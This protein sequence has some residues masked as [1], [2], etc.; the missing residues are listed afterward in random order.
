MFNPQ[1]STLSAFQ[2]SRIGAFADLDETR[3]CAAYR[4]I[5]GPG[6]RLDTHCDGRRL[7]FWMPEQSWCA[8]LA[9]QLDIPAFAAVGPAWTAVRANWTLIPLNELLQR[10]ALSP[11]DAATIE[12]ADAPADVRWQFILSA[13]TR[14]LPLAVLEAP[15]EWT[16]AL[17]S[18]LQPA[19]EQLHT[20]ALALG[21]CFLSE[22]EWPQV[23]IGDA[24]RIDGT[25]PELDTF[26]LQAAHS[27]GRI[28][29]QEDGTAHVLDCAS[30]A[31]D[32]PTGMLRL[33]VEVGHASVPAV[34]L[35]E[36]GA[37][38][39]VSLRFVRHPQMRLMR[40]NQLVAQGRLLKLDDGWAFCVDARV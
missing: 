27:P 10:A 19:Q 5:G 14:R 20:L 12:P 26:W 23:A 34:E 17:L 11:C 37:G 6:L 31:S 22:L 35:A 32:V 3:L 24:L 1:Y 38:N 9:P 2:L 21:W 15:W 29:I 8:W 39:A 33:D 36:W 28:R 4:A 16:E 25:G 7:S 30:G 40:G 18:A 13:D